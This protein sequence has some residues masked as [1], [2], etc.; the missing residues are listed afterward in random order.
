MDNRKLVLVFVAGALATAL[1]IFLVP[2][3]FG[4]SG[5]AVREA[6]MEEGLPP[7]ASDYTQH[8]AELEKMLTANPNDVGTLVQLGNLYY[9]SYQAEALTSYC[10]RAIRYYEKA[11]ALKPGD[12]NVL[13]DLGFMYKCDGQIPQAV[14][15]FRLAMKASPTHPQ[16]RMN[17]GVTLFYE[18]HDYK[19][20]REAFKEFLA[21]RPDAQQA[22]SVNQILSQ[23][24]KA[25]AAEKAAPTAPPKAAPVK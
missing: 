15:R 1:I 9:D 5:R 22:A 8:I 25:E 18:L 19:G 23:I 24:D 14:A 16:S 2:K 12:P 13:T 11:L 17:L 6:T 21:L 3:M 7:A 4:P 10:V 20:A